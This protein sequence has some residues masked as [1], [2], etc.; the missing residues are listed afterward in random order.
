MNLLQR[1]HLG[2]LVL[3]LTALAVEVPSYNGAA[4]ESEIIAAGKSEYQRYCMTCHGMEGKGDGLMTPYLTLR[5]TDLTT[6][7]Q[8]RGGQFPFW[9]VYRTIDGRK[10]LPGYGNGEIPIWGA[11]FRWE[12]SGRTD[13]VR[14]RILQLVYYLQS[15]QHE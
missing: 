7:R 12:E 13:V 10:M 2:W 6:L 9:E 14:G 5:P 8:R 1:K 4:Q 11:L 3:A 15:I